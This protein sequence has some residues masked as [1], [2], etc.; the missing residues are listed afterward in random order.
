[1]R[2]KWS[3]GWV[4]CLLVLTLALPLWRHFGMN[5]SLRIDPASG[6][7]IDV[8]DDREMGGA[9]VATLREVDHAW[10]LTCALKLGY[11]WPYC[12]VSIKL[13]TVPHGI[14][15]SRFA[16]VVLD[17]SASGTLP[18]P[19]VVYLRN[20]DAAYF[21][22]GNPDTLKANTLE[23]TPEGEGAAFT[24]PIANFHVATWWIQQYRVEG[25]NARPDLSNVISLDVATGTLLGP[26]RYAIVIRSITFHGKWLSQ[27]ELLTL[28]VAMWFATAIV[29]LAAG[30]WQALRAAHVASSGRRELERANAALKLERHALEVVASHDPLTRLYNRD[31]FAARI[32]ASEAAADAR[33][34]HLALIF[35]DI[36]HFKH[37]N[38]QHGHAT[39][40]ECLQTLSRLV[41]RHIR[42]EDVLCRWGGEEFVLACSSASLDVAAASAER[43][44][45]I[46]EAAAWPGGI[47]L[48]CSFGVAQVLPGEGLG[49][50]LK[51]A[52]EALYA[53][54]RAGRNCVRA[55][56]QR[57]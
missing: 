4:A 48:T 54:K 40:D 22:P 42:D 26:G 5:T 38:D 34:G 36:D 15:L 1:M 39:G 56:A 9:S 10:V 43:L 19:V 20:Y 25:R 33:R 8:F 31:G 45:L 3:A 14:D 13:G 17:V 47:S 21:K 2:N 23:Y 55:A 37:V 28:I 53:A 29:Y 32:K 30:L 44:R 46:L 24:T 41:R 18:V 7:P 50:A 12:N 52:D 57:A 35:M 27:V 49:A 11:A 51:R 16:S 6:L